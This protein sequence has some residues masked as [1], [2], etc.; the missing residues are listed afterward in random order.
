MAIN[1]ASVQTVG[2]GSSFGGGTRP[3]WYDLAKGGAMG[4]QGLADY[5]KANVGQQWELQK[6]L[7]PY[8]F[9]RE[10]YMSDVA[11]N[12][13]QVPYYGALTNYYNA[14]GRQGQDDTISN[15]LSG[16]GTPERGGGMEKF[17]AFMGSVLGGM[18]RAVNHPVA[19]AKEFVSE[20]NSP[21]VGKNMVVQDIKSKVQNKGLLELAKNLEDESDPRHRDAMAYFKITNDEDRQDM[22]RRLRQAAR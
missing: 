4:M 2:S 19:A 20:A 11:L 18:G 7:A 12:N 13:A 21:D 6:A 9:L 1:P 17:K 5:A 8:N 16:L 10:K 15:L 3:F 14:G 22:I